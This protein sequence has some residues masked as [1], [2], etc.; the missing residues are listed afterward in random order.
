M[1]SFHQEVHIELSKEGN[2]GS[3]QFSIGSLKSKLYA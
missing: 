1:L 2:C 3:L